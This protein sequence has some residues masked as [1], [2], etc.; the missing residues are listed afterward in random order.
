MTIAAPTASSRS[1]GRAARCMSEARAASFRSA[2]IAVHDDV[3]IE[4]VVRLVAA[5]EPDADHQ[6]AEQGEAE[7][8]QQRDQE[9]RKHADQED[10][11]QRHQQ[12]CLGLSSPGSR[13]V[14]WTG[15]IRPIW[16][17]PSR[18]S[19][20]RRVRQRREAPCPPRVALHVEWARRSTVI[21]RAFAP[22]GGF[23]ARIRRNSVTP[24]AMPARISRRAARR[25]A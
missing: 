22:Q 8:A 16:S 18:H 25:S 4:G 14:S 5:G 24:A 21:R 12:Q 10:R 3:V 11:Q 7:K 9:H 15:A 17:G 13:P 19:R 1:P 23:D 20:S 2:R 6:H